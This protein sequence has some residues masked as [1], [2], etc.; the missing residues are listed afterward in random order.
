MSASMS[1][2]LSAPNFVSLRLSPSVPFVLGYEIY[3]EGSGTDC[4][5]QISACEGGSVLSDSSLVCTQ[6]LTWHALSGTRSCLYEMYGGTKESWDSVGVVHGSSF[7]MWSLHHRGHEANVESIP[8]LES[9]KT[10]PD[11]PC[12]LGQVIELMVS[13]SQ[14]VYRN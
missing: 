2:R 14:D 9:S 5:L 8:V 11:F 6:G 1:P 10:S 4:T 12:V 3:K 13:I 7:T